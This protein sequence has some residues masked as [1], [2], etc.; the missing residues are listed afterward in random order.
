MEFETNVITGSVLLEFAKGVDGWKKRDCYAKL[1][2][3]LYGGGR[4]RVCLLY[5]QRRTGQA[6]KRL[7]VAAWLQHLYVD[8]AQ[9]FI[10]P[11][12]RADV[13]PGD[14]IQHSGS[15]AGVYRAG[16]PDQ[17]AQ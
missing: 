1:E 16:D 2:Q 11:F 4:D 6:R 7:G 17:M 5:G 9:T 12:Q 14:G 15:A 13:D 3:Y 8:T 10:P